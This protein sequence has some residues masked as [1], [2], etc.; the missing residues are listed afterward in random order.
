M[1]YLYDGTFEGLMTCIYNHYKK[2]KAT[3]IYEESNYQQSLVVCSKIVETDI[4][5]AMIVSNAINKL[6]SREAYI[7]IYYCFLSDNLNKENIILDFLIFGFKYGRKT[8]NFYTHEKVLPIN[9]IYKKVAREEH[10]ILGILRFSDVGG[11]LYA[12]YS[13]DN[14][15]SILLADHF[16]DRYKYEKFIIYDEKRQKALVYANNKWEI[17]EKVSIDDIEFSND[18]KRIQNLWKQ[19]FT[20]LA[21]K[22]R[23]NTNLQFQFVPSRYRKNM[24]EFNL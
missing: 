13:P 19:Y 20:D 12:K 2:E 16:A 8:M 14:D 21:I 1:D 18:E 24:A 7:H 22:E 5:K 10:R 9:E 17:K 23:K 6:I 4:S 15:I 3:G 11:V